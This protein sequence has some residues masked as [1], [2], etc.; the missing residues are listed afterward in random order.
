MFGYFKLKNKV[1]DLELQLADLKRSIPQ[2][3]KAAE[4][5]YFERVQQG[6]AELLKKQ[7][8]SLEE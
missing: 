2:I 6:R 1:A 5:K 7:L 4:V 8:N 3:E